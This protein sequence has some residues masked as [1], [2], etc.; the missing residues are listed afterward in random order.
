MIHY[1]MH[2]VFTRYRPCNSLDVGGHGMVLVHAVNLEETNKHRIVLGKA[3]VQRTT[4]R[5]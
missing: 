4:V 3:T 1:A 5:K 2:L